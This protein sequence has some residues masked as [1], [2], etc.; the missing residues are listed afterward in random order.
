MQRLANELPREPSRPDPPTPI[1]ASALG[2]MIL[3]WLAPWR[4]RRQAI[5]TS[6][7]VLKLHFR[8]LNLYPALSER[9]HLRH[10]VMLRSG[11]DEQLAESLLRRAEESF[12][13]WPEPRGLTLCDVAHYLTFFELL[14]SGKGDGWIRSDIT[15]VIAAQ[16]PRRL[17]QSHARS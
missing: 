2:A 5:R 1:H 4:E 9:D 3:G 16:L 13:S 15:H 17:C 6:R 12:A 10:V 8:V 14:E 11:V 7:A